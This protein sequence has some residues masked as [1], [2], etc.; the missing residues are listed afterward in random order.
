MR[1]KW[2][3][4]KLPTT[5]EKIAQKV[6]KTKACV[7]AMEMFLLWWHFFLLWHGG[8]RVGGGTRVLGV[9]RLFLWACM[10]VSKWKHGEETT[11]CLPKRDE[12]TVA[13]LMM[14][15]QPSKHFNQRWWQDRGGLEQRPG[16]AT[17]GVG[18]RTNFCSYCLK[19]SKLSHHSFFSNL[20]RSSQMFSKSAPWS[21]KKSTI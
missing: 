9:R 16:K 12:V 18:G 2:R 6:C 14:T 17:V 7:L 20:I 21:S 15:K 3:K 1:T 13:L 4:M 19:P 10:S 8:L 11:K 5:A